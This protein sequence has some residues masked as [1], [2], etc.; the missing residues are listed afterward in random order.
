MWWYML[1]V[2]LTRLRDAQIAG[3]TLFLGVSDKVFLEEVIIWISELSKED[4]PSPV[5]EALRK[6][7]RC[8]REQKAELILF[9]LLS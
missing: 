1:Y 3:K 2:N 4:P 6:P 5:W 8:P 9:L 7:L